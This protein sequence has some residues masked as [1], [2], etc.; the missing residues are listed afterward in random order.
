MTQT[1]VSDKPPPGFADKSYMLAL[2]IRQPFVELILNGIK[3]IEYR[4]KPT[5]IIGQK[6]WIY[7]SKT[8][9]RLNTTH[10]TSR[11][12]TQSS[13]LKSDNL[14]PAD[15]P[16]WIAELASALRLFQHELPTGLI[17]GSATIEKVTRCN[18]QSSIETLTDSDPSTFYEWHLTNIE[19]LE[20]PM[21]PTRH[22]QP[23]WFRPFE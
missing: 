10:Q 22:P 6:F 17:V 18:W 12:I 3:K 7:A 1:K 11:F 13:Q 4:S 2:S 8:P 9:M 21:K 15:V 23:S 5:K 19:R 14:T 20:K 16:P